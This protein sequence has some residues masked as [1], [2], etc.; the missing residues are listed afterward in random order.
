MT[1]IRINDQLY[2]VIPTK[3]PPICCVTFDDEGLAIHELNLLTNKEKDP[4]LEFL[5][6]SAIEMIG[7][8]N[9]RDHEYYR[10]KIPLRFEGKTVLSK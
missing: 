1:T 2:P 10:K 5:P 6:Y 3:F 7:Q 4:V 9:N 8:K